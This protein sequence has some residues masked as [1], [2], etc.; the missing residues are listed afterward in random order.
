M[1]SLLRDGSLL[2]LVDQSTSVVD[3]I[4]T[5]KD[6]GAMDSHGPVLGWIK[7]MVRVDAAKPV[8]NLPTGHFIYW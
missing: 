5:F 1:A 3:L 6:G 2:E 8:A 7:A 4:Q